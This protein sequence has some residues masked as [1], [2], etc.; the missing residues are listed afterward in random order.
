MD[1]TFY[2]DLNRFWQVNGILRTDQKTASTF[3][4]AGSDD[5]IGFPWLN[6]LEGADFLTFTTTGA[7][8]G[9]YGSRFVVCFAAKG[10]TGA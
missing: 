5:A 4:A 7:F 2:F 10:K 6:C 9:D 8:V 3:I 1:A